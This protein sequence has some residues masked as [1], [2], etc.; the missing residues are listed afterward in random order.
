MLID[1]K[2]GC[3]GV[4]HFQMHIIH[5]TSGKWGFIYF[6][7]I[8]LLNIWICTSDLSVWIAVDFHHPDGLARY[9]LPPLGFLFG[10]AQLVFFCFFILSLSIPLSRPGL[11]SASPSRRRLA[12]DLPLSAPTRCR[13][14]SFD[15]ASL[16]GCFSRPGS[17]LISVHL[18]NLCRT[19]F[20]GLT[21][22]QSPDQSSV[23][24]KVSL[25]LFRIFTSNYNFK[26]KNLLQKIL[27]ICTVYL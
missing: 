1:V 24:S 7:W 19:Q 4:Q 20:L 21:R 27:I 15:P 3:L 12:V 2:M 6:I 23:F 17:L 16:M 22:C 13:F 8:Y 9:R 18:P 14:P 25:L 5:S 11:L 26:K 10:L